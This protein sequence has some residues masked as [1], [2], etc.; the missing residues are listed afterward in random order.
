[1]AIDLKPC[2]MCAG[3]ASIRHTR[4]ADNTKWLH[5]ECGNCG[6]RTRGK[7]TA[8]ECPLFYAEVRDE[9]N[10]RAESSPQAALVPEVGREEPVT[11]PEW[12]GMNTPW[13]LHDV[14]TILVSAG[15]VLLNDKDYDAHGHENIRA[16]VNR[17]CGILT[18]LNLRGLAA[19]PAATPEAVSKPSF[20]LQETLALRDAIARAVCESE[21]YDPDKAD[22]LCIRYDHLLLLLDRHLGIEDYMA[23]LSAH[24]E[25]EA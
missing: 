25:G 2:P 5:V 16:A 24:G 14:L 22:A 9:W 7:W 18:D 17:A 6:C 23:A 20:N 10:T 12:Y 11:L 13:P 1:M 4:D 19:R 8:E 21:P 15:N 3:R